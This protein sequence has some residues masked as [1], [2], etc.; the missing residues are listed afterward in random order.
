MPAYIPDLTGKNYDYFV[1]TYQRTVFKYAQKVMFDVPVFQND[2]LVVS[3]LGIVSEELVLG[4]SFAVYDEDIDY[5]AMAVC[6]NIDSTFSGI[7]LKSLTILAF[8]GEVFRVQLNF[9]QL[10]SDDINYARI[11]QTRDEIEV[12]P[13][14]VAN[15]VEQLAYLQ[16]LVVDDAGSYSDQSP[17]VKLALAEHPNG[18]NDEN[19]I[20]DELH[21][22]D[23]LSG[24]A[25]IRP[26]YGSF[27]RD[28]ISIVNP[29]SDQTF[30]VDTDFEVLDLDISRTKTTNNTSGVYR[31]VKIL[32]PV[33]GE[34]KVSYRAYGGVA[35]IA[36]MR[37]VQDRVKL[38][39]SYL[40]RTSYI[41]P[42]TLPADPTVISIRNKLQELEGT[43]RLLL[44]NGLPSYG[45]VSTGTA[46]LKRIVSQDT[47][48]H[49][50]NIASLYRVEG[51]ADDIL[52]DVFKFRLKSMISNLMFECAVVVNVTPSAKS[53][54][55]VT[56]YNSNIPDDTLMKHSPLLRI[57]E[58]SVGGIYSGVMLQLGMRLTAGI[59]QETFDIEDMSGRE[60]CW[61]LVP[62]SATSTPPEDT[63][64]L[65]PNGSSIFSYD[66]SAAK[67]DER[68]IPFREGLNVLSSATNLPLILGNITGVPG[69]TE[70]VE[71]VVN[72]LS[73]I[74]LRDAKSYS[75]ECLANIGEPEER[76]LEFIVPIITKDAVNF[77]WGGK[78]TVDTAD[79]KYIIGV[80]MEHSIPDDK[81][82]IIFTVNTDAQTTP[83]NIVST[84]I[85]F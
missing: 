18:D 49:W 80:V 58:V 50:W 67:T 32:K 24:K 68:V 78:V 48:L 1:T 36:S 55:N 41:T 81:Y 83:L 11:N 63:G 85:L 21:D 70:T 31:I 47:G 74:E 6:K 4:T 62:F 43:M 8:T 9:N 45:D 54:L 57:V 12:T 64:F 2:R 19:L 16:Q 60:S 14:L 28:S 26:I 52:S 29:L 38:I 72:N 76:I 27:F 42:K 13:T 17:L 15:M 35:D 59:L 53:R 40:S 30:E 22:I 84:K 65:M 46:V 10:F 75:I 20:I 77:R 3:K 51:S 23:T 66:E 61:K 25:L 71:M 33:V 44:Q 73:S 5:D 56:C 69:T 34:L 7:L 37:R 82:R 79:G 39:E